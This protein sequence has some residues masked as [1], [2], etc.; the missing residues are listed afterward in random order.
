MSRLWPRAV[1]LAIAGSETSTAAPPQTLGQNPIS[2]E[3]GC[4]LCSVVQLSNSATPNTYVFPGDGVLTRAR[5]YVGPVNEALDYAQAR[6]FRKTGGASATVVSQG[7]KHDLSSLTAGLHSFFERIPGKAG[8]VLGARFDTSPFIEA[9][10]HIFATASTSDE[11]GY[12]STPANPEVGDPFTSTPIA[13]RRVNVSATFEPDEDGDG[14][15]D[16]S[17]DLCPGAPVATTACSGTLLGSRLQG[18]YTTV[19]HTCTYACL[20]IQATVDGAS[21]AAPVDG[22]V[23]RWR[24]LA[25]PSGAY[26]IRVLGPTGGSTYS[27][28]RSSAVESVVDSSPFKSIT[29]VATRLPIPAGGY[30][31]LAP[32][33]FTVQSF[34]DSPP[35]STYRQVNDGA[36]GS[37]IDF[38]GYGPPLAGEALYDADVEPDADGDGFGDVSQDACPADGSTQGACGPPPQ[39]PTTPTIQGFRAVP[40][41]FRVAARGAVISAKR[42]HPGTTLKLTLSEAAKVAFAVER[43][44]DCRNAAKPKRCAPWKRVHSFARSL[45]A[46]AGSVRYSG[47]YRQRASRRSLV[48]GSYR[49]A[50]VA[51]SPAGVSSA[52]ARTRMTVVR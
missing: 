2:T 45:G 37:S 36:D 39:P 11:A 21:T 16:T 32:P 12:L 22:V 42:A 50:A 6:V 34:R 30:V 35:D 5:F 43:R 19:G 28:L 23:V 24:L 44:V 27:V 40:G 7:E 8:D 15:G 4:T 17:Q 25:A 52:T 41:R 9:T 49:I 13:N 29:T 1:L 47:R 26:R 14:Y 31:A 10:P 3:G 38:A 33:L 20:R 46:G 18:A 48:P 51:T